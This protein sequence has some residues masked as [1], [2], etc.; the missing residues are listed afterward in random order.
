MPPVVVCVCVSVC[1]V[2]CVQYPGD[3]SCWAFDCGRAVSVEHTD[4]LSVNE[5]KMESACAESLR[6]YFPPPHFFFSQC[7]FFA[8]S[9]YTLVVLNS[10]LFPNIRAWNTHTHTHTCTHAQ[11]PF[12][13]LVCFEC[14]LY[15]IWLNESQ[16][17]LAWAQYVGMVTGKSWLPYKLSTAIGWVSGRIC[18]LWI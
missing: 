4:I 5:E 8:L 16:Y 11:N 18:C 1:A 6:D 7:C 10:S 3:Q 2:H 14:W 9:Y 15:P 12:H 17:S 13:N